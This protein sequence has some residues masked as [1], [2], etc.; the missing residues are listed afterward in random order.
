MAPVPILR[1]HRSFGKYKASARKEDSKEA[2]NP[3]AECQV[4]LKT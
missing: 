3:G 1:E 4:S 2:I